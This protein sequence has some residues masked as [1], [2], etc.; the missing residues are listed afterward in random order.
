MSAAVLNVTSQREER[1][2]FSALINYGIKSLNTD[3]PCPGSNTVVVI[4]VARGGT[5]MTAG[6]LYHLGIPMHAAR[7]P[8]FEDQNIAAVFES[9]KA[10]DKDS[11]IADANASEQWAWKRPMAIE[12]LSELEQSL[13]NPRFIFVFRDIFALANRSEISTSSDSLVLMQKALKQYAV[14]VEY[15]QNTTM[16]CLICSSEKMTRYP[17]ET[18]HA[19]AEFCGLEP[20][21]DRLEAAIGSINTES[22]QYLRAARA[23]RTHGQIETVNRHEVKGWAA[24]WGRDDAAQVEVYLNNVL[25]KVVTADASRPN[26]SNKLHTR[27]GFCGFHI[28]FSEDLATGTEVRVKIRSDIADLENSPL[29]I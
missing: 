12:Y 3:E 25:H 29:L 19:V 23:N 20:D 15:L 17:V 11:V 24:W 10:T 22:E 9:P 8:V 13:R 1:A 6:I 2:G 16:P 18:V 28:R 27:N 14:A 4:G 26:L 21:T 5:S 7:P